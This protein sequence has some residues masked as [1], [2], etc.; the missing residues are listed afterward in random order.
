VKKAGT[1]AL[2]K[3]ILLY[4]AADPNANIVATLP[5]G[6][7][8]KYD[9]RVDEFLRIDLPDDN[10]LWARAED[11]KNGAQTKKLLSLSALSFQPHRRPPA[12]QI[13][14]QVGGRA[15]DTDTLQLAGQVTGRSLRDMYV[16]LND[17]KVFYKAPGAPAVD[18]SQEDRPEPAASE[19]GQAG[20][21]PVQPW[22]APNEKAVALPFDTKLSLQDGMNKVLIVARLDERVISYR[23]LFVSR[24]KKPAPAVA[25]A[26]GTS[27]SDKPS[28]PH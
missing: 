22:A 19:R 14:G 27:K 13:E 9:A 26:A 21:A 12:I 1:G 18:E 5:R 4:A 16:V 3:D 23:T 11:V 10:F 2:S 25:E 15:V 28:P 6:T 17:K 7:T 24:L 20:A 8:V